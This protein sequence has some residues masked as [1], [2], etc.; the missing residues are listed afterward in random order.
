M[1]SAQ[2]FDHD[3]LVDVGVKVLHRKR[4]SC[5]GY[6][7]WLRETKTIYKRRRSPDRSSVVTSDGGLSNASVSKLHEK[8]GSGG[9]YNSPVILI[10]SCCGSHVNMWCSKAKYQ[11]L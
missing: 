2:R 10:L 4:K 11:V 8:R 5:Y 1:F 6:N 9:Y 7:G 3:C